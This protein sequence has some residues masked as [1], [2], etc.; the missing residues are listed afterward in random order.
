[1]SNITDDSTLSRRRLLIGAG[2]LL[3]AKALS[4]G[5]EAVAMPITQ[6]GAGPVASPTDVT[7]R[8]ARYMVDACTRDL[9]PQ[10]AREAKHRVLDTLAAIVSGARLKPGEMA[11][12]YVR[13][14]GGAPEAAVFTTDI[15]TSAVNAAPANAMFAHADETDDF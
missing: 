9:P 15:R 4:V 8:V 2:G 11:A 6:A 5:A 7:G 10:V 1:M 12:R 3:A 14:A 13:A